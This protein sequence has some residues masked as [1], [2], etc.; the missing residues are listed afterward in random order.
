L[1]GIASGVFGKD[2]FSGGAI[3]VLYG[4]IFHFIIAYCFAIGFF[5]VFPLIPFLRKQKVISGLLYGI[6]VW[7]VMNLIVLPLS[8]TFQ[9]AFKWDSVLRAVVILMLCVG[10]PVSLITHKYYRSKKI[11]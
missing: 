8:N 2:A 11:R 4:I 6:F 1:Q 9:S 10:L 3:M 7:L 5:M